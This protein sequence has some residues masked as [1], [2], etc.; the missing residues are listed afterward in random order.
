MTP[1]KINK[2]MFVQTSA[3]QRQKV[4]R[5]YVTRLRDVFGITTEVPTI[6]GIAQSPHGHRVLKRIS[7]AILLL[8]LKGIL[9]W[10]GLQYTCLM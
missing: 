6:G 9:S 7:V 2:T 1:I 5:I 8:L 4:D 10:F 3:G